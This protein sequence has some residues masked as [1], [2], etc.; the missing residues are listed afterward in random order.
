MA[1][2]AVTDRIIRGVVIL[3]VFVAF[4]AF[5]VATLG[6]TA[7]AVKVTVIAVGFLVVWLTTKV[8]RRRQTDDEDSEPG[9]GVGK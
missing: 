9:S 6:I 8:G 1:K 7:G 3:M 4:V 2:S 5:A